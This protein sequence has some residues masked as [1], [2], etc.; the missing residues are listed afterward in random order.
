MQC[1]T[2]PCHEFGQG[3]CGTSE[4]KSD[5]CADDGPIATEIQQRGGW[6]EREYAY[7]TKRGAEGEGGGGEG[8]CVCVCVCVCACVCVCVCVFSI[9]IILIT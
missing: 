6:G 1:L 3:S 9:V 2:Q 7:K 5:S 8:A 4:S